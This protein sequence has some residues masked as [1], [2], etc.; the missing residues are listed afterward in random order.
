M[1]GGLTTVANPDVFHHTDYD[2]K[3]GITKATHDN[4]RALVK[5]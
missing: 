5:Y 3:G 1:N 4:T 2:T